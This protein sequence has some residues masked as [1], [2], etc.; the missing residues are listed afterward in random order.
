MSRY[1]IK[2]FLSY[3]ETTL[4]FSL[5][6]TVSENSS[7]ISDT[8]KTYKI[9][10]GFIP[11]TSNTLLKY[12]GL[13]SKNANSSSMFPCEAKCVG[14]FSPVGDKATENIPVPPD[15][16]NFSQANLAGSTNS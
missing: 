4:R 8:D 12:S 10:S 16:T 9:S 15:P 6:N 2:Y 3:S 11:L 14:G 1:L 13:E 7:E 5:G